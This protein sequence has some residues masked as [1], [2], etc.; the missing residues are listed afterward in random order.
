VT[1]VLVAG[2]EPHDYARALAQ[3][4]DDPARRARMS[5]AAVRHARRFGWERTAQE[6]L[7]VYEQAV[8]SRFGTPVAV[9]G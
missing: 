8:L 3:V 4:L 2:H 6:T 9:N 5:A 1:G 7:R